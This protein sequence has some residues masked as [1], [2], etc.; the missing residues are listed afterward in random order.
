L[1]EE[2][3]DHAAHMEFERQP[4]RVQAIQ[5][6]MSAASFRRRYL[7]NFPLQM[8]DAR[9]PAQKTAFFGFSS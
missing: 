8:D 6:R 3:P 7:R 9:N 5:P 4:I 1:D 2:K